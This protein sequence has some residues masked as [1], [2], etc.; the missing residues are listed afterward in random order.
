MPHKEYEILFY[1]V[2]LRTDVL[3]ANLLYILEWV[4]KHDFAIVK[5]SFC[6]HIFMHYRR[7]QVSLNCS[8]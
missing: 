5:L 7:D 6:N 3:T 4:A 2:A 8:F 1:S